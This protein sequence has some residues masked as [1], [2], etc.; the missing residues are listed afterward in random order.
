[1]GDKKG[2]IEDYNQALQIN[3]NYAKAYYLRGVARALS[4][5]KKGAIE[6]F[7]KAADLFQQQGKPENAQKALYIIKQI[8]DIQ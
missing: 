5:D 7:Q 1:L 8:T 3:P 6:D 2:A 4:G